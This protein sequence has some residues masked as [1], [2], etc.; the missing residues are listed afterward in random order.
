MMTS[1]GEQHG[2]F[3]PNDPS[4]LPSDKYHLNKS[5]T[6]GTDNQNEKTIWGVVDE[7]MFRMNKDH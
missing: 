7:E 4:L 2:I 5:H 1:Y 6:D 3:P